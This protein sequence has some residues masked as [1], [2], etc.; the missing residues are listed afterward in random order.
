[1]L[2]QK[3]PVFTSVEQLFAQRI[4]PLLNTGLFPPYEYSDFL[5]V[6]EREEYDET[7]LVMNGMS[8][9]DHAQKVVMEMKKERA[10]SS[11]VW[12]ELCTMCQRVG[13]EVYFDCRLR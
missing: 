6:F 13:M 10:V 11:I 9:L 12:N 2:K 7:R 1:M 8:Y 3:E 5:N 4:L